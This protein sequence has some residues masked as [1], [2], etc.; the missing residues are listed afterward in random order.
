MP[1]S[2]WIAGFQ[3]KKTIE[4]NERKDKQS[5]YKQIAYAINEFYKVF[6]TIIKDLLRYDS[7]E[8]AQHL[9]IINEYSREIHKQV[10]NTQ[11]LSRLAKAI[12]QYESAGFP[13]IDSE[14][15]LRD[16]LL[17]IRIRALKDLSM[18]DNPTFGVMRVCSENSLHE[19]FDLSNNKHVS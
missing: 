16:A 7:S 2:Y 6:F 5:A 17:S 12:D 1:F 19:A 3:I 13:G 11:V 9:D 4:E 15:D 18:D 14:G 10:S 8:A